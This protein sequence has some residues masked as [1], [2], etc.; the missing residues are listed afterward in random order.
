MD[1]DTEALMKLPEARPLEVKIASDGTFLVLHRLVF[2][3]QMETA[4]S[5]FVTVTVCTQSTSAQMAQAFPPA[6]I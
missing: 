5:V 1:G 4:Q 6:D 2:W 3:K